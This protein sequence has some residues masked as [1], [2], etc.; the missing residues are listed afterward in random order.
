MM[1]RGRY[2]HTIDSKGRIKIPSRY[3]DVLQKRYDQNLII[4]NFDG[5]LSAFPLKEWSLVEERIRAL[6]TMKRE[7]RY[8]KRFFLG[9][10]VDCLVDKQRRILIPQSLRGYAGLTRDVVFVG[11]INRFEVWAKEK[12]DPQM[13]VVHKKSEEIF[14]S[15]GDLVF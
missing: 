10:A 2:E 3:W 11:V 12:L 14:E 1:F 9:G 8:F 6:P 5:C 13:D 4:T 15:L 7:V